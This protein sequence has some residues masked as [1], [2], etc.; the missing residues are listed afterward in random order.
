MSPET[1]FTFV[2]ASTILVIIPGPTV[3]LVVSYALGQGWRAALP[4]AVGVALGDFTAMTLS[5]LGIGALLIA[6]ATIFTV[7]KWIGA[8]YLVYL[9]IRLFRTGGV[10]NAEPRTAAASGLRMLTHAWLVTTLNPKGLLFFVAFFPQFVG[11]SVSILPQVIILKSTFAVLAFANA[12]TYAML[13]SRARRW[14]Q[15]ER[16]IKSV[17]QGGGAMLVSAGVATA[18]IQGAR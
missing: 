3:L 17:N 7:M 2:A 10:P 8:A 14:V 12:L 13:A 4:M 1:W 16:I 18:A 11:P 9:G 15:D 6:S 5:L